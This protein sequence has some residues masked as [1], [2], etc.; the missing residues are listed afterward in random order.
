MKH[1][2]GLRRTFHAEWKKSRI[3]RRRLAPLSHATTL[4]LCDAFRWKSHFSS[5]VPDAKMKQK[6]RKNDRAGQIT[7]AFKWRVLGKPVAY[8]LGNRGCNLQLQRISSA[9]NVLHIIL[10]SI[11]LFCI[12]NTLLLE[13]ICGI[14]PTSSLLLRHSWGNDSVP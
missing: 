12:R 3:I 5:I 4:P 14:C 8:V 10:R 7:Y 6:H 11:H 2:S 9:D 1:A 13:H